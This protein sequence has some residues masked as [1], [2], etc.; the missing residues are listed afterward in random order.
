[1]DGERERIPT[2]RFFNIFFFLQI[3]ES[4]TSSIPCNKFLH[5]PPLFIHQF[6]TI[7]LRERNRV[8]KKG[9]IKKFPLLPTHRNNNPIVIDTMEGGGCRSIDAR[10]VTSSLLLFIY[11]FSPSLPP[12]ASWIDMCG[13]R[14]QRA[15]DTRV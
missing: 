15:I 10:G 5:L 9:K 3:L 7:I 4:Y 11:K 13:R 8:R 12:L 2:C 14:A 6:K 1:M